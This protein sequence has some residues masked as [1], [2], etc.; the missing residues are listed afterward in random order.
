MTHHVSL[1]SIRIENHHS[2]LFLDESAES[3]G[4]L[5]AG[6]GFP[7]DREFILQLV[8][9]IVLYALFN[10]RILRRYCAQRNSFRD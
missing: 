6:Q 7:R 9:E 2:L 10:L 3:L 8:L 5:S 4:S 1:Q